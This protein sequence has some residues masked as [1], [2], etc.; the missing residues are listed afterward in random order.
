MQT[1]KVIAPAKVNL[2]LGIGARR[3]DGYHDATTVMHALAMHDTLHMTL[4][5]AG[6]DVVLFEP[7]DAA[8]PMRQ[9]PVAVEQGSGLAVGAN[10]RWSAGLDPLVISDEDNLACKAVRALAEA[11]GRVEDEAFR[12]VIDKKI[13][14]Q[15]GLGGGSADAA[16]ALLGAAS[17]WDLDLAD[18]RIE[19][20]ARQLGADVAFFI[21]GGCAL[22]E[23]TGDAF[24]RS[25]E[26]SKKALAIIKPEGGVSTA[27]AYAT[28]DSLAPEVPSDALDQI[29]QAASAS[30]VPLFNNLA[31]ASEQL[32]DQLAEVRAFASSRPGVEGVLLCGSGAGTFAVCESYDAAAALATAAQAHGWWA[33]TTSFTSVG[34]SVLPG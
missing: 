34:A 4:V 27:Q 14:H 18:K 20:T 16:A 22:L 1:V 32:H 7:G 30:D 3:D 31:A 6:E 28:F 26:P 10:T 24:V 12:L 21:H 13:P 8:Q 17:L 5:G 29:A 2:F 33:R 19:Q 11:I 15:T 9:V 23:G 25:L